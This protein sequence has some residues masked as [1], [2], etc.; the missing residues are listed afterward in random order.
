MQLR[1]SCLFWLQDT[2][3]QL[4]GLHHE[5]YPHQRKQRQ[6]ALLFDL[7]Y[8]GAFCNNGNV[9]SSLETNQLH[10]ELVPLVFHN[11]HCTPLRCQNYR[12]QHF[13]NSWFQLA[14]THL[15]SSEQMSLKSWIWLHRWPSFPRRR[16]SNNSKLLSGLGI[17]W[18]L[19]WKIPH[20]HNQKGNHRKTW[21]TLANLF[22]KNHT[23][24]FVWMILSTKYHPNRPHCQ[25]MLLYAPPSLAHGLT[26]DQQ[27]QLLWRPLF[28]VISFIYFKYILLQKI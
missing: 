15:K 26:P 9:L 27:L 6:E 10:Q 4:T 3:A 19:R 17:V 1:C 12:L 7:W 11:D 28:F 23:C 13:L 16:L 2:L 22:S 18:S 5:Q 8:S 21:F 24:L 20:Q 25:S 14:K